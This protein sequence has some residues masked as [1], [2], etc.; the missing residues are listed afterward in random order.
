VT[1]ENPSNFAS[2]AA[3]IRGARFAAGVGREAALAWIARDVA[4]N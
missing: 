4:T 1:F 2:D 3:L